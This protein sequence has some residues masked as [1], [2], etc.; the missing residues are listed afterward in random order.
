MKDESKTLLHLKWL[1]E[2]NVAQY[3]YIFN[4]IK[5]SNFL[6]NYPLFVSFTKQLNIAFVLLKQGENM[7]NNAYRN[8]MLNKNIFVKI[9]NSYVKRSHYVFIKSQTCLNNMSYE[10]SLTGNQVLIDFSLK[11]LNLGKLMEELD[12]SF[13]TMTV[14]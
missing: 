5:L 8:N 3:R 9:Y 2:A 7:F 6:I 4:Q 14:L 10:R 1:F 12:K 13:L 11:V